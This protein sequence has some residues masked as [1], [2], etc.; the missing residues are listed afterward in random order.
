[1]KNNTSDSKQQVPDEDT[2][3]VSEINCAL[4]DGLETGPKG[5]C[6]DYKGKSKR[7]KEHKYDGFTDLSPSIS[8][9]ISF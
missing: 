9:A 3:D 2:V 5:T 1:M 7:S 4:S 8:I 6:D